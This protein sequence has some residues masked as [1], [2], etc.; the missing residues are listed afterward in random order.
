MRPRNAN[1]TCLQLE[2][3]TRKIQ[4]SIWKS[5]KRLTLCFENMKLGN[6]KFNLQ[7]SFLIS[8][9]LL[10][11]TS[12][13]NLAECSSVWQRA[14]TWIYICM[15]DGA[16]Q[17]CISI[18]STLKNSAPSS[19][20]LKFCLLLPHSY[21]WKSNSIYSRLPGH[22]SYIFNSISLVLLPSTPTSAHWDSLYYVYTEIIF[23]GF[24]WILIVTSIFI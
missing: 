20:S 6:G 17:L 12:L 4:N 11:L 2:H 10:S 24:S 3:F 19:S 23:S 7:L 13:Q 15:P 21:W 5:Y 9:S 22:F 14:G 18:Y 8:L 1:S 16:S